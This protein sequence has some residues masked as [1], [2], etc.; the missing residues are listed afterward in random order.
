M[1]SALSSFHSY[2]F[3]LIG[4]KFPDC[5]LSVALPLL[6]VIH[7]SLTSTS[8]LIAVGLNDTDESAF[9]FDTDVL[10]KYI[11]AYQKGEMVME[12]ARGIL[13]RSD[14]NFKEKIKSRMKG[15]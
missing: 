15:E 13:A 7:F 14:F 5:W 1:R 8:F 11:E 10:A 2:F 12:R 9:E 4:R 3:C 6:S